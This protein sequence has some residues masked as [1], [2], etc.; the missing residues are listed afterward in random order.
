MSNTL[1]SETVV[2]RALSEDIAE[3][4]ELQKTAFI[5]EAELYNNFNLEPLTQTFESVVAEFREYSYLKAVY[6]T[7]IIGSVR[8][9][10]TTEFCWIGRLIVHPEYQ[11]NGIGKRL[12]LEIE[13][14]FPDAKQFHLFTGYKSFKNIKLYESIGYIKIE[15][16]ISDEKTPGIHLVKMIK[17]RS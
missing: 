14:E 13:N 17:T 8:G 9:R 5:S 3:I 2:A 4:L 15:E 11:N 7:K 6:K 1:N 12:M 10:Q 16:L